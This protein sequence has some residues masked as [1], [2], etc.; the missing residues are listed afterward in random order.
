MHWAEVL[1]LTMT[2]NSIKHETPSLYSFRE[3]KAVIHNSMYSLSIL[4]CVLFGLKAFVLTDALRSRNFEILAHIFWHAN[5]SSYCVCLAEEKKQVT[6]K[7]N[8]Q[9]QRCD[10]L[11]SK[12][13][14]LSAK[15]W[16]KIS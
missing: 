5:Y 1:F 13:L 3:F 6:Q 10:I 4:Q 9:K 2:H 11:N 12:S 7:E 15:V 16:T 8:E 14:I